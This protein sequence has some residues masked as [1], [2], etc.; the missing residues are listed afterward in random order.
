LRVIP[1]RNV[2]SR[3]TFSPANTLLMQIA[4]APLAYIL[5]FG[6]VRNFKLPSP[7]TES[8]FCRRKQSAGMIFFWKPLLLDGCHAPLGSIFVR[9]LHRQ[10]VL[11]FYGC[12]KSARVL[13]GFAPP[14]VTMRPKLLRIWPTIT[15]RALMFHDESAI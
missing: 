1:S 4:P 15:G 3:Q 11:I 7:I 2:R 12:L 5:T 8:N 9:M 14:A 10:H 13:S 6:K